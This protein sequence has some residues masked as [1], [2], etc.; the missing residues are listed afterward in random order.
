[1]PVFEY[2]CKECDTVYDVLHKSSKE[3]NGAVCP[4]CKSSN[5]IKLISTFSSKISPGNKGGCENG[6]CGMPSSGGGCPGG[7]CGM[8]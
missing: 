5:S 6:N 8:N 1:M 7:M 4:N 2:K 3:T